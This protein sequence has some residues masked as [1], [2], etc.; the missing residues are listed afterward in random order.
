MKKLFS[1]TAQQNPLIGKIF[2]IGKFAVTVED[3]IAQGGFAVVFLVKAGNGM[4][5]AL[6]R[7][8]V[9]NEQDLAVCKKEI[10]IARTLSGHKNIIKFVESSVT[11]AP[12]KVFEVLILMQY[13]RGSVIQLLNDRIGQ[14]L[15]EREVLRIFC[16]VCEAVSR[17]H[18]CQTPIIHRDLKLENVL[19]SEEGNYVL[20]DFGSATARVLDKDQHDI[21]QIE[22]E[23][24]KYTTISYRSPE[25]ID[26]YGGKAITTK[27]DIWALGCLLY[28]LCFLTLP[29]GESS[30]A[31]QS[32]KFTIPDDSR[33]SR[34]IHV[35]IGYMLTEDPEKRPD[36]FQVSYLAFKMAHKNT[37]VPNMN[38]SSVPDF[39]QLPVPPTE[40]E[41]REVKNT[42]RS[43]PV[44]P[45]EGSTSVAPR[46]RPK[47]QQGAVVASAGLTPPVQTTIAPRQRPQPGSNN[48][49]PAPQ[50][51]QQQL[52]QQQQQQQQLLQQQQQQQQL[53]LQQQQLQQK[54]LQQQQPQQP[55]F[56]QQPV[57]SHAQALPMASVTMPSPQ[58]QQ[59]PSF[60]AA[61]ASVPLAPQFYSPAQPGLTPQQYQY[62]MQQQMLQQQQQYPQVTPTLQMAYQQQMAYQRQQYMFMQQQQ[63]HPQQQAQPSESSD[64]DQFNVL[65]QER[66]QIRPPDASNP[67]QGPV[68]ASSSAP[69]INNHQSRNASTGEELIVFSDIE[70]D[71]TNHNP[72]FQ[73]SR[74]KKPPIKPQKPRKSTAE[75]QQPLISITPPSSPK[76][77]PR[78]HRRNVSD[79]SGYRMGGKG[80]A[81]HAYGGSTSGDSLTAVFDHKSKS[82]T[83]SP[84]NSPPR[85]QGMARTMSMDEWN[86]FEEDNFGN[87]TEDTIFGKEFDKLRRGSN[88]SISNVKSREDLVMSGSD[89]STDPFQNAPFKKAVGDSESDDSDHEQMEGLHEKRQHEAE[90]QNVPV[91]KFPSNPLSRALSMASKYNKLVDTGDSKERIDVVSNE[92]EKEDKIG[93]KYCKLD[94]VDDNDVKDEK[95]VKTKITIN[96]NRSNNVDVKAYKEQAELASVQKNLPKNTHITPSGQV[97]K[98]RKRRESSSSHADEDSISEQKGTE[99]YYRELDDEYGSRPSV[100]TTKKDHDVISMISTSSQEYDPTP[101]HHPIPAPRRSISEQDVESTPP[102]K[103]DPIIGHEHGVRPLL[104][105]DELEDDYRSQTNAGQKGTETATDSRQLKYSS[106]GDSASSS[107]VMKLENT[108]IFGSAP[109]KKKIVRK[110]RPSSTLLQAIGDGKTD[111]AKQGSVGKPAV[112]PKPRLPRSSV[113]KDDVQ[114]ASVRQRPRAKGRHSSGGEMLVG[115]LAKS[116][117]SDND[118]ALSND[119]FSNAPFMKRSSS[120]TDAV[121]YFASGFSDVTK[122]ALVDQRN[123]VSNSFSA[124]SLNYRSEALQENFDPKQR[125]SMYVKPLF[126]FQTKTVNTQIETIPTKPVLLQQAPAGM[127]TTTLAVKYVTSPD[128]VPMFSDSK[129][130]STNTNANRDAEKARD[131]NVN[132]PQPSYQKFKDVYDS[133]EDE[134]DEFSDKTKY[135]KSHKSKSPRPADRNMEDSAF[136]NMSFNDEFEDEE[137]EMHGIGMSASMNE[138]N[139]N[140]M[141]TTHTHVLSVHKGQVGG[142]TNTSGSSPVNHESTKPGGYDTFTW[143]RKRHKIPS[144]THATAEPF[145]VKKKV[146]SIFK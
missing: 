106:T 94:E 61:G 67:A 109:F 52:M 42:A 134:V 139:L 28:R 105:D 107:P 58:T 104:D 64:E 59:S 99:F 2:Q 86:P 116:D 146:D 19:I 8:F 130:Q 6:K 120:S 122:S 22:E 114:K 7:M 54:K 1:S 10:H 144:K 90:T 15:A 49:D 132:T 119:I 39:S 44:A 113:N 65:L 45:S 38:S 23:I 63:R 82:A 32:G 34:H 4:R 24:Q 89:S 127:L 53:L 128:S 100:H 29:F 83:T 33:F 66:L 18:H 80:S 76:P 143:P 70:K 16:D 81:F 13:C 138:A 88:S 121:L 98:P 55:V 123:G 118:T 95:S 108:D 68:N 21:K 115:L 97:I 74:F 41:A 5:Y 136:S 137:N 14:G 126:N 30:L 87:E 91:E 110:K 117:D 141:K 103:P 92:K 112:P 60:N 35:L 133:D 36:I 79:T 101:K 43:A 96:V 77:M 56:A 71:T 142:F 20:C 62:Y 78:T 31:I 9:N 73:D 102:E 135:L 47:A 26:L 85:T 75:G 27:A 57:P 37:P 140:S 129:L 93:S 145:T 12:N 11:V 69:A 131:S 48:R 46:Q 84:I 40:S 72:A 17:L 25:M 125:E 50:Q 3:V 51:T 124:D 111:S